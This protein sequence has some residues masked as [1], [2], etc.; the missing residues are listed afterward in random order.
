MPLTKRQAKTDCRRI[1]KYLRC[2]V[3]TIRTF[4]STIQPSQLKERCV[5]NI[6]TARKE[7][8]RWITLQHAHETDQA[9]VIP[10]I[11]THSM[12]GRG[13]QDDACRNVIQ[14]W[15]LD[16]KLLAKY[17]PFKESLLLKKK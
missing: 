12:R 11:E 14:Y 9:R 13:T 1:R 5:K 16:G 6:H 17:D 4:Y 15:S 7:K 10:V 3:C 8:I 2:A